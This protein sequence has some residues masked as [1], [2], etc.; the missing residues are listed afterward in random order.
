MSDAGYRADECR[1]CG[2]D[3]NI[4]SHGPS[5][6]RRSV[7]CEGCGSYVPA[8]QAKQV[9]VSPPDEYYPE[10]IHTCPSCTVDDDEEIATDGGVDKD[11]QD[12]DRASGVGRSTTMLTKSGIKARMNCSGQIAATIEKKFVTVEQLLDAIEADALTERDGIGPK[13]AEAIHEWHENREK[14]EREV[15]NATTIHEGNS[16]SIMNNG[17]WSEAL[18]VER[19]EYEVG[20]REQYDADDFEH[21]SVEALSPKKA[22]KKAEND[23]WS[24]FDEAH[25][26]QAYNLDTGVTHE[27]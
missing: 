5:C 3:L 27:F 20:V 19:H 23:L 2:R 16:I 14:I 9:D 4:Q 12:A 25:A 21:V 8:R 11:G 10:T 22:A 15:P 24:K 26:Y 18:G 13:T 7:L 17:D 1:D 6:P